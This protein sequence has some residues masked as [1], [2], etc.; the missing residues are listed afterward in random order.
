M[1]LLYFYEYPRHFYRKSTR[2]IR[3]SRKPR[4]KFDEIG[5]WSEIK[6]DIVREYAQAYSTIL[7]AQKSLKHVYIDA[8]AGAGVHISKTTGKF[9]KGSP[10][11]ALYLEPPFLEYYFIDTDKAKVDVL[12]EI[13]TGKS[14]VHIY[15]GDCNDVLL[16]DVFPMV[17]YEDYRRGL[18]LLD[19][20]GI[21]LD[22]KVIESAGK[23]RSIEIFLNFPVM[24]MNMNVLWH[25]PQGVDKADIKRMNAFWGDQSWRKIAYTEEMMLFGPEDKRADIKVVANAFRKRLEEVAGFEY[26]PEPMPM[27]NTKGGIVYYLFF[28]SQNRTGEKILKDIFNKYRER[29]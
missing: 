18:C 5:Y 13:A 20:Y 6:L 19:P 9:V 7:S 16:K 3:L 28:A 10:L 12:K 17:R 21:H 2:S 29:M 4:L 8:F 15:G 25:N 1:Y 26:V 24:D 27:K 11:N 14:N 23:M 22:W